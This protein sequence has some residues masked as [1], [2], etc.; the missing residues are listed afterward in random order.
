[1][2]TFFIS[3]MGAGAESAELF[4]AGAAA[5]STAVLSSFPSDIF[6]LLEAPSPTSTSSTCQGFESQVRIPGS[7]PHH[8]EIKH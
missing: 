3:N 7:D 6:L 8:R 1:M 2:V 4:A 5:V